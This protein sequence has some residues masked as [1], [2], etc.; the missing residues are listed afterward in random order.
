MEHNIYDRMRV[1]SN[2]K[3]SQKPTAFIPTRHTPVPMLG[4][5]ED[6]RD[7]PDLRRMSIP[8]WASIPDN[9]IQRD[10]DKRLLKATHL[11]PFKPVHRLVSMAVLPDGSMYK[12]DGHTRVVRW[13][14]PTFPNPPDYVEVKVYLCRDIETVCAV[15]KTFDNIKAADNANDKMFG[16]MRLNKIEFNSMFMKSLKY[17]SGLIEL[18]EVTF[19][20]NNTPLEDVVARY[21]DAMLL[22]DTITPNHKKFPTGILMAA[23]GSLRVDGERGL[24][25][26]KKYQIKDGTITRG[27]MDAV[28]MLIE[29][30]EKETSSKVKS[31][32]GVTF[33]KALS[34]YLSWRAGTT[35]STKSKNTAPKADTTL[36]GFLKSG[37]V[38]DEA[39]C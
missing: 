13:Q 18:D 26:W 4:P 35:Y 19:G 20:H 9:P 12:I 8:E 7:L 28:Q 2:N 6:Y 31:N 17:H 22:L 10:T 36:K 16:A 33:R 38:Q 15:H 21:K 27:R 37:I 3:H 24:V 29:Y 25:F 11:T 23:L 39:Q 34:F 32:Y 30:N 5:N 1:T 14:D